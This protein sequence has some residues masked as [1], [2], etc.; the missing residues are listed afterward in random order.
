VTPV[1]SDAA[2]GWLAMNANGQPGAATV[3]VPE[4]GWYL[5]GAWNGGPQDAQV[6]M[7]FTLPMDAQPAPQQLAQ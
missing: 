7:R 6:M 5:L 4:L 2:G 3:V 1:V